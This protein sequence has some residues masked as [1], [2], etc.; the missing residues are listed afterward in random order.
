FKE[1]KEYFQKEQYSLAYPLFKEL[2]QGVRET[3]RINTSITVQEISYY[4]TTCAL[5]QNESRAEEQAL[6]YIANEKNNARVDMMHFHLG[7]YFF[8]K[9]EFPDAAKHYEQTNIVNLN[10][11]EIADMKFHQGYAYFTMQRFNEAK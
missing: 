10:N 1:A 6:T 2:Q 5:K 7:E 4:Y 9:Q 8:R 11:R 3:D